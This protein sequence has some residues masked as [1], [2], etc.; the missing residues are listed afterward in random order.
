MGHAHPLLARADQQDV[1]AAV[2]HVVP[3]VHDVRD[4]HWGGGL[5]F[6]SQVTYVHVD[7]YHMSKLH[8]I[9]GET[10]HFCSSVTAPLSPKETYHFPPLILL[11]SL[12]L[13]SREENDR[14]DLYRRIRHG[15]YSRWDYDSMI[16][17]HHYFIFTSISPLF[18]KSLLIP[19]LAQI[20]LTTYH[21]IVHFSAVFFLRLFFYQFFFASL[22]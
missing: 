13:R 3:G 19:F 18:L 12:P 15:Q 10:F 20:M 21:S 5:S 17:S 8:I 6:V 22:I 4:A 1:R 2:R 9:Q 7:V 11:L 16:Y 14:K